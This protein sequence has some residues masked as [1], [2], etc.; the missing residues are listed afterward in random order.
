M[1]VLCSRWMPFNKGAKLHAYVTRL[2]II[3]YVW[4]Y[5]T[6]IYILKISS[7]CFCSLELQHVLLTCVEIFELRL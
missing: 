6:G 1:C 7:F 3:L 2:T 5:H 4:C